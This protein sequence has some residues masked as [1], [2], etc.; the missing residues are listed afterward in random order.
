MRQMGTANT[1]LASNPM[2]ALIGQ[3][4]AAAAGGGNPTAVALAATGGGGASQLALLGGT[5]GLAANTSLGAN[6][7]NFSAGLR[8]GSLPGQEPPEVR[9]ECTSL[10]SPSATR[11][12]S[13]L[14]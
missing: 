2:L 3:M 7:A 12:K 5:A 8:P 13:T 14:P 4:G 10:R 1:V 6:S 11:N 9:S